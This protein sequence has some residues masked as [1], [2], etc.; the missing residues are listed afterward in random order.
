M[1]SIFLFGKKWI[2]EGYLPGSPKISLEGFAVKKSLYK[3]KSKYQVIEIFDTE[4]FGRMFFL[5]GLVQLSTKYEA[6]YHEMLVHPA[7]LSHSNPQTVL[8]IG[9]GDG[10]TLRETLKHP[11]KE[12][13]LVEIDKEVIEVSKKY[14]PSVSS[15]AFNDSRTKIIIADGKD[16]IKQYQNYFDCIIL[17]SNDPDGVMAAGLFG[18]SFF[19]KVKRALKPDG[20]F[21]LQAGYISDKFGENARRDLAK[22]FSFV[23]VHRAFVR[24]FP[25]DEHTFVIGTS[26]KGFMKISKHMIERAYKKR[27]LHTVYYSPAIHFASSVLPKSL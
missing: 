11:V 14:L 21:A 9:G 3:K 1:K 17:D 2:L 6:V 19:Q 12:V 27:G 24:H 26:R 13:F 4:G 5:D 10:G 22:V 7:M 25:D 20:I 16:F 23:Q 15:G 18:K 8:I